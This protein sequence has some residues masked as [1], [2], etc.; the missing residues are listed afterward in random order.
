[1]W[2]PSLLLFWRLV[3]FVC[4]TQL[5]VLDGQMLKTEPASV[6]DKIQKFLSLANIINYHKILAWVSTFKWNHS[7]PNLFFLPSLQMNVRIGL[8]L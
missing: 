7:Q 2:G 3:L 5:L 1:M 6:M 4:L 8:Q